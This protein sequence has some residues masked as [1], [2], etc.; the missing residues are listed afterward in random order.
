MSKFSEMDIDAQNRAMHEFSETE[1]TWVTLDKGR[2]GFKGAK[3]SVR[4]V[5]I[6]FSTDGAVC[7]SVRNDDNEY[8][9]DF[10]LP[11]PYGEKLRA[12]L[13]RINPL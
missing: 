10:N 3:Q 6:G 5:V 13:R 12:A 7:M 9:G 4:T 2:G 8:V 1:A 11:A